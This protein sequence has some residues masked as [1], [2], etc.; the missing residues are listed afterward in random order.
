MTGNTVLLGIAVVLHNGTGAAR[1]ATALGGFALG[2]AAGFGLLGA[3]GGWPAR[4]RRVLWLESLIL[5]LLLVVWAQAGAASVRFW[6]IVM[7]ASR[8]RCPI[9]R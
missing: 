6:L 8:A 3:D 4:A 1:S 5:A 2:A 9:A 7:S